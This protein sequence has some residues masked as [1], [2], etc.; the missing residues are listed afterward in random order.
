MRSITPTFPLD[1]TKIVNKFAPELSS[2]TNDVRSSAE[3][4][5]LESMLLQRK[6][7]SL[8]DAFVAF[9]SYIR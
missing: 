7:G 4:V 1:P 8:G 6:D 3:L 5:L 9:L 2:T